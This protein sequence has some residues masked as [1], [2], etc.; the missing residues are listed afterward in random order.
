ML[1]LKKKEKVIVSASIMS[2][3]TG[4]KVV[5]INYVQSVPVQNQFWTDK[6]WKQHQQFQD[7]VKFEFVDFNDVAKSEKFKGK[8]DTEI[9]QELKGKSLCFGTFLNI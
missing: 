5:K 1:E 9:C 3:A 7:V 6:D 4:E 8:S 2:R